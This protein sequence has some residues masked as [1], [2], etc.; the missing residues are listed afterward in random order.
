MT[1]EGNANFAYK[2]TN[3]NLD[4]TTYSVSNDGE[5]N[6]RITNQLQEAELNKL[7]N[8]KQAITYLS[9]KDWV[10]TFP[11]AP[12]SIELTDTMFAELT[13]NKKYQKIETNK[14]M[15]LMGQQNGMTLAQMIGKDYEDKDWEKLLDQVTYDEMAELIGV[16]YHGTQAVTSV[17][18]PSTKDE[19]GPQGI[20][21]KLQDV[22]GNS[23]TMCA[24]TDENIMAATFNVDLIYE[25]GECIGEDGLALKIYGLYG[26]AMNTHRSP[27]SGRN[28]EYYSEDGFLGGKIAAAETRGIQSKGV[29]VYL[30]HFAFNDQETHCRC[31]AIFGNEQSLREIYLEP[32]EHAVIDGEAYNVMNSFSRVG[33]VWTGAHEG[34]MTN[35]LRKEWGMR[36]FA[37]TDFSSTGKTYDVKLGV[38]AGSDAWDASGR[39]WANKLRDWE[40]EKD[41]E[42]TIAMRQAT[43]RILYTVANSAAMNGISTTSRIV[44]VIPWWQASIYALIGVTGAG[45]LCGLTLSIVTFVSSIMKKKKEN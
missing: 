23:Q 21:G 41:V 34:L 16:G 9:R 43:K 14:E 18:K 36:G 20:S 4:T 29:Y 24:Y 42:L 45:T 35:I 28:F 26:P 10:N 39:G 22:F 7:E 1:Y 32:F 30:K 38:L 8:G 31:M 11:S 15:P 37:L 13:G 17:A 25:L 2:W 3:E 33:V 5:E 27:Y 44:K 6:Y 12:A 40:V 19:N